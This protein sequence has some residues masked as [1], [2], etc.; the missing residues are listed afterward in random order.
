MR[1]AVA[2]RC[3]G[4]ILA[5]PNVR[6][7]GVHPPVRSVRMCAALLGKRNKHNQ[8]PKASEESSSELPTGSSC[9]PH[10]DLLNKDAGEIH[11]H[12]LAGQGVQLSGTDGTSL[13]TVEKRE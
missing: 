2:V 3:G 5:R 6:C 4:V 1:T 11:T 12:S 8:R 7:M 13:A 10:V 9:A